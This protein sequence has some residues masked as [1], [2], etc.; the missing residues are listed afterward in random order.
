MVM[1]KT[2]E[3]ATRGTER[4][5]G[6]ERSRREATDWRI[7]QCSRLCHYSGSVIIYSQ[8]TAGLHA[9]PLSIRP[10]S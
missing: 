3:M 5:D 10:K 6:L 1:M 4:E 8:Y 2:K 7:S 9:I